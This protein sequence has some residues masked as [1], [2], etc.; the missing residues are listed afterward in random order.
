MRAG[1]WDW[2]ARAAV[3]TE[4][5]DRLR[6][7]RGR[8]ARLLARVSGVTGA[9]E[10][11]RGGLDWQR[12]RVDYLESLL[13]GL[14]GASPTRPWLGRDEQ[15][16]LLLGTGGGGTRVLAEAAARSGVVLGTR[17]NESFDSVEWA[18]LV[19]DLVLEAGPIEALPRGGHARQ[20]IAQTAEAIYARWARPQA[21]WG[22]KLPEL[23]LVLPLFLD[24]FP[25]AQVVL[26]TRH[27]LG[28]ALRRTHLTTQ[29]EHPIGRLVLT[30]AYRDAGLD[31]A[32]ARRDPV[33]RRNALAW[34]FQVGRVWRELAPLFPAGR[35][36][37]LRLE[38]F[39][40]EPASTAASLASFL[41]TLPPRELVAVEAERIAH[42]SRDSRA[43]EVRELCGALAAELGYEWS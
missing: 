4:V 3:P 28:A 20:A 10:A 13:V 42:D 31:P 22:L 2:I 8:F 30:A 25:A 21:R 23:M 17:V 36:L 15:P 24:A 18:P 6:G 34:R 38:D 19:Y 1:R 16:V 5:L 39:A 9:L 14:A 29:P 32:R 27:P 7:G 43:R 11:L 41:G 35:A 33:H 37:H 26:L 12:A 40:G